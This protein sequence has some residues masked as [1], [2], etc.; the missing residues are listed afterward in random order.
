MAKRRGMEDP[1][2]FTDDTY[3]TMMDIRVSTSTL[4]SNALQVCMHARRHAWLCRV[5]V[6]ALTRECVCAAIVQGGGFGPISPR[7][8]SCGYGIS[9]DGSRYHVMSN[10]LGTAEFVSNIDAALRDM[11]EAIYG[12]VEADESAEQPSS[13]QAS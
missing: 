1:D 3:T 4:T 5:A 13:E 7:A 9:D 8:Y 2:V 10:G 6:Y 11:R 12:A